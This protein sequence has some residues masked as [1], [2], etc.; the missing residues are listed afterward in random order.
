VII[1]QSGQNRI[2]PEKKKEEF[3]GAVSL[4]PFYWVVEVCLVSP[5]PRGHVRR[6]LQPSDD[7]GTMQWRSDPPQGLDDN[8]HSADDLHG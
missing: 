3:D 4:S 2:A 7:R 6:T 1:R 5:S 8:G